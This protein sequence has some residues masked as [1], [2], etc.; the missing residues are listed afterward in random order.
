[1]IDIGNGKFEFIGDNN[2]REMYTTAHKAISQLEMWQ[3]MQED[4][5][6]SGFMF[7]GDNRVTIIGEKISQL[8]Y[9]GHSGASFAFTLRVMQYI[10][11]NGYAAYQREY[12]KQR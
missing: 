11:R 10:A 3:F 4:P 8:G 7:S 9:S 6:E 2:E 1:M 12:T 5:G